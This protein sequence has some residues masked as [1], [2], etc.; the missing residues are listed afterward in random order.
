MIA[1]P[2]VSLILNAYSNPEYIFVPAESQ[3]HEHSL[4]VFSHYIAEGLEYFKYKNYGQHFQIFP[5]VAF[6][7]TPLGIFT[8]SILYLK[9]PMDLVP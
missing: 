5:T 8:Q 3:I 6:H 1:K 2:F 9:S 7:E 4:F